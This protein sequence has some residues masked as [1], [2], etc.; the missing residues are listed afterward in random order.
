MQ[1][2]YRK[3]IQLLVLLWLTGM[4]SEVWLTPAGA[5]PISPIMRPYV[6]KKDGATQKVL[7]CLSHDDGFRLTYRKE[8]ETHVTR[9]DEAL[10]TFYWT[11]ESPD[12]GCQLFARREQN[13]ILLQGKYR[14]RAVDRQIEIDVAPWFQATSLSLKDFAISTQEKIEF[15]TLRPDTL[16]AYKLRAVKIGRETL[17]VDNASLETIKIRL[18]LTGWLAPFW[19]SHYWFDA[20]NGLFVRFE[21]TVDASG[22]T[23]IIVSYTG[24]DAAAPLTPICGTPMLESTRSKPV[25]TIQAAT[26]NR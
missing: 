7:W 3:L 5:D 24:S 25:Q 16:K 19:K 17:T 21:G 23:R 8:S 13:T 11:M 12:I 18:C 20:T 10:A 2:K 1:S 15:W 6:E 26:E 22:D 4:L 9:T 14:G